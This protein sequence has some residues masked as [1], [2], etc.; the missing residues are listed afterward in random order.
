MLFDTPVYFIFLSVVALLYWSFTHRQQNVLLLAASYF[1]YAWWDWRF[2]ILIVVSTTVDYYC[3]HFIQRS[4]DRRRRRLLLT[5]SVAI[6]LGFLGVFKY[7]NFFVDSF[8]VLLQ[9]L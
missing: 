4:V 6:N 7:F 9:T 5:V 8:A 3:A 2:L 1:F